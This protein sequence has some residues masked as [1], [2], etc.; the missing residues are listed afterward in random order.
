MIRMIHILILCSLMLGCLGVRSQVPY[1]I[2]KIEYTTLTRG[3]QKHVVISPD[4]I[5]TKVEGRGEDQSQKRALTKGEWS[6]LID[7]LKNVKLAEIPD[8]KSPSMK[9]AY[10][11]ALHSTLTLTTKDKKVL[12]HSFDNEDAN[13]K[14]LPLMKGVKKLEGEG[15]KE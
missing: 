14:L 4:S 12:S 11:G 2:R 8:L 7:C 6:M 10:D 15:D 3:Y 5:T 1:A 13:E 9:R